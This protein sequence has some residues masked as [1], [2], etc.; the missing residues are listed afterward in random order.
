MQGMVTKR[1]LNALKGIFFQ[2]ILILIFLIFVITHSCQ[3]SLYFLIFS[4]IFSPDLTG[5]FAS[6]D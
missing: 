1:S 5:S 4:I 6:G 2:K 3:N